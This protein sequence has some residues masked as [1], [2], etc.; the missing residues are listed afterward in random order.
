MRVSELVQNPEPYL[1]KEITLTG[2]V[3]QVFHKVKRKWDWYFADN[4][5][6]PLNN[7]PQDRMI[8]DLE[9]LELPPEL[10]RD[11]ASEI[12][13][14]L[15][16]LLLE[17]VSIGDVKPITRTYRHQELWEEIVETVHY[18]SIEKHLKRPGLRNLAYVF[19]NSDDSWKTIEQPFIDPDIESKL[20][21]LYRQ[22][23]YTKNNLIF[24]QIQANTNRDNPFTC[25]QKG[26]I[27]GVLKQFNGDLILK[28]AWKAVVQT[29]ESIAHVLRKDP[30][31][32]LDHFN[33]NPGI[34]VREVL[35]VPDK[36][37]GQEI[38][39][40]G[41]FTSDFVEFDNGS[42]YAR[43]VPNRLY[44]EYRSKWDNR[45]SLHLKLSTATGLLFSLE[46]PL[47]GGG[48]TKLIPNGNCIEV[49]LT[50]TL[51]PPENE[52]SSII[53]DNI[54]DLVSLKD[55]LIQHWKLDIVEGKNINW[56]EWLPHI[57]E[58]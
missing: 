55:G 2:V 39:I 32:Y 41:M 28:D 7:F 19:E 52:H 11:E 43:I 9:W 53:L 34:P 35:Q 21:E 10:D 44:Y 13:R 54:T 33:G 4:I 29:D 6:H 58:V 46:E 47:L 20:L 31:G 45:V 14:Q 16:Q 17:N 23:T 8:L 57:R 26:E 22:L 24:Y 37:F 49:R 50:G 25:W 15:E 42:K 48:L 27:T 51:I 18:G 3:H 38:T 12:Y 30:L 1:G 5:L 36:F 40:R 56:S